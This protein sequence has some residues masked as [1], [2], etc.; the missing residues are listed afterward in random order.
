MTVVLTTALVSVPSA[1]LS[2]RRGMG[3]LR[4]LQESFRLISKEVKPAVVNVSSVRIVEAHGFM[5][6]MDPFF[7]DDPFFG[8]LFKEFFGDR[9]RVPRGYR[10]GPRK[11][12][13]QGLGSGFI[14]DPRGYIIT[15]RH[16]IQRADEIVVTLDAKKKFKAKVVGADEKTD[17]AV[18]KIDGRRF[19]IARLGSSEKLQVGDWV[20]AI[21]N[22]LGLAKTVTA[23]IVSAKGRKNLGYFDYEDFIQTDAAINPGNSG[24][25]LVN[26][27]GEVV[28]INTAIMSKDGGYMGIGFAIPVDLAKKVAHAIISGKRYH[29][30]R[31]EEPDRRD[32]RGRQRAVP[33]PR[34][35]PEFYH[36]R[37]RHR[38]DDI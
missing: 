23:G 32:F 33:Q 20:L 18:I 22:P 8:P 5:P 9:F 17:V 4:A 36:Y 2:E 7:R 16:V 37:D 24:G 15:N 27:D 28:G 34:L 13:Q 35:P 21:G 12:R 19:P 11:L 10:E 31:P 38:G 25:P 1:A 3:Q 30:A 26:I 6:G 29:A 14:I